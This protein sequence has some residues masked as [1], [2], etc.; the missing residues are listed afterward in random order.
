M[1]YLPTY[2]FVFFKNRAGISLGKILLIG[3]GRF[4]GNGQFQEAAFDQRV[5]NVFSEMISVV[6]LQIFLYFTSCSGSF[7]IF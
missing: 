3:T 2:L 7:A 1:T 6:V 5:E 4:I